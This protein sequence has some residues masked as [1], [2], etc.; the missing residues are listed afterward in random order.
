MLDFNEAAITVLVS[1]SGWWV[2]TTY[3][4]K[5]NIK[6]RIANKQKECTTSLSKLEGYIKENGLS[7]KKQEDILKLKFM[8]LHTRIQRGQLKSEDVLKAYQ[9]KAIEKN[10]NLN[11]IVEPVWEAI[12]LAAV[13]DLEKK[14]G[15]LHG[16]PVSIKENY[17]MKGYE[18]TGGMSP[19]LDKPAKEDG[20]LVKVLKHQGAVPFVRTNIPQSMMTFECSNPIYGT[21]VNPHNLKR[22]PGG[23]SGGEACIL[24]AEA[25]ILGWGSDIGGSLRIPSSFCGTCSLKPTAGRLSLKA[26]E[27]L[28]GGRVQTLIRPTPGPMG[29]DVDT[30]VMGMKAVLCPKH[31]ELDPD[32]PP[33]PFNTE[34]YESDRKLRIG[35]Y[36][37]DGYVQ[38]IPGVERAVHEAKAALEKMGHTLVPFEVPNVEKMFGEFFSKACFGD[39]GQHFLDLMDNDM[40][41]SSIQLLYYVYKLPSFM[42]T[43]LSYIASFIAKDRILGLQMRSMQGVKCVRDWWALAGQI[44]T[45]RKEFLSQWKSK[46]LDAIVCPTMPFVA[47]PTGTVKY[48]IGGVT[49]TTLY[50]VLNYPAGCVPVTKVTAVDQKNMENY[51]NKTGTEKFIRKYFSSDTGGLPVTVQCVALPYQEELAL[52]VMKELETGLEQQRK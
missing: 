32:V 50:N 31:F 41:D 27:E 35:Y 44:E 10:K 37:N 21:T 8:D 13:C 25:S 39:G 23:S 33:L 5:R 17:F 36:T 28:D 4:K 15:L 16:V 18:S 7:R 26:C 14:K 19:L 30:V 42:Q 40:V 1:L 51:P 29:R 6:K 45:Y 43:M 3:L 24:G 38:C 12:P 47:P 46:N 11:F 52:R 22:G 48:L 20:V 34:V 9:A 49:Y 2:I